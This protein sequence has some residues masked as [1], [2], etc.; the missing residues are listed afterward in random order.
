MKSGPSLAETGTGPVKS[1]LSPAE[2]GPGL[3]RSDLVQPRLDQV[4]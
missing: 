2:T 3:V 1:G 4:R